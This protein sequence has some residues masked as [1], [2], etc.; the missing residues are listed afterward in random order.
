VDEL[1]LRGGKMP[2]AFLQ[3]PIYGDFIWDS[4]IQPG[5]FS[6]LW[7]PVS[8][9]DTAFDLRAAAL[10]ATEVAA[11]ED[12]KMLGAQGNA[13]LP[14]DDDMRIHASTSLYDWRDNEDTVVAGN[15]GNTDLTDDF[16]IWE[17][18]VSGTVAGGPLDEMSAYVELFENLEQSSDD[19]GVAA[20]FQVG[21]S[22][23]TGAWNLFLVLYSLGADCLFSPVSQDDTP[24]AGTG[25]SGSGDGM[26]G[27]VFGGT[28]F[29]KDNVALKVWVLTSDADAQDD[30][31]RLR[32]DLD[33]NVK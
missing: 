18:F 24:I 33:F 13:F 11:D 25:I 4:D 30:P 5:G 29:W 15:Q 9:S 6:A 23:G 14:L 1:E 16:L 27:L 28:Y 8:D 10:V 7:R 20:G 26:D 17:S 12:P 3:P 22:K 19:S 21:P 2:H 31:I 32:F